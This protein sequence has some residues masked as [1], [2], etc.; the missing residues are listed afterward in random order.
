MSV[1]SPN[2]I[3]YNCCHFELDCFNSSRIQIPYLHSLLSMWKYRRQ[4]ATTWSHPNSNRLERGIPNSSGLY[5]QEGHPRLNILI[6][7]LCLYFVSLSLS[8]V[9]T[10]PSLVSSGQ[11]DHYAFLLTK[12]WPLN[13]Y[14]HSDGWHEKTSSV[15]LATKLHWPSSS[16]SRPKFH[17]PERGM[18]SSW[19]LYWQEGHPL[20]RKH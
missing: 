18:P 6:Y 9:F 16:W 8:H 5:W 20:L 4:Q 2:N 13:F 14:T 12:S 17:R 10:S 7:S 15:T 3:L 1:I 19:S 11:E